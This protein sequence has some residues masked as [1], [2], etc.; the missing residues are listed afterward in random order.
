[1]FR[2][3]LSFYIK[4]GYG[5]LYSNTLNPLLPDLFNPAEPV[6]VLQNVKHAMTESRPR[7]ALEDPHN[8]LVHVAQTGI[9][10]SDMSNILL[11]S[12]FPAVL[13]MHRSTSISV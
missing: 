7:P 6:F 5:G 11:V 1:M 13:T 8:V 3:E 2:I 10:S 4:H 12:L 9:C